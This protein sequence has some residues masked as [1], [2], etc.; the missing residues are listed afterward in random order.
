MFQSR[1]DEH[2]D[3]I[4]F[5][6][7]AAESERMRDWLLGLVELP[8]KIRATHLQ[9]MRNEMQENDEP[10]AFIRIVDMLNEDTILIAMNRVVADVIASGMK[11]RSCLAEQADILKRFNLLVVL[12]NT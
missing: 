2:Q 12:L 5:I 11:T 1:V 10:E 8:E 9:Q 7:A 6:D 4:N 3:V